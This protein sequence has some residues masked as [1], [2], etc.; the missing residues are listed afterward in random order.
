MR[1]S[2]Y[3][4]LAEVIVA[5]PRTQRLRIQPLGFDGGPTYIEMDG[6]GGWKFM[7]PYSPSMKMSSAQEDSFHYLRINDEDARNFVTGNMNFPEV[8]DMLV[9]A[10]YL[11]RIEYFNI[12]KQITEKEVIILGQ[13]SSHNPVLN[14]FDNIFMDRSGAKIHFNH[15]WYD[16]TN[17]FTRDDDTKTQSTTGHTTFVGSRFVKLSGKRFLP[18]G[19]FSHQMTNPNGKIVFPSGYSKNENSIIKEIDIKNLF[20]RNIGSDQSYSNIYNPDLTKQ[21]HKLD[22]LKFLDPPCPQPEEDME[23]HDSGWKRLIQANANELRYRRSNMT[24]VGDKSRSLAFAP[25]NKEADGSTSIT[26]GFSANDI[27]IINGTLPSASESLY[28]VTSSGVWGK[29]RHALGNGLIDEVDDGVSIQLPAS[30][31]A[32]VE[33]VKSLFDNATKKAESGKYKIYAGANVSIVIDKS[34]TITITNGSVTMTMSGGT[35]DVS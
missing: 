12:D 20:T 21:Q 19:G 34:G 28:E 9:I 14:R 25:D 35:V 18:F 26:T 7:Q 23:L 22:N 24:V 8:G 17:V 32:S 5:E 33:A 31:P 15:Q 27:A 6:T 4:T 13:L 30:A 1:A 29:R 2:Y 10:V 11:H 16:L 3:I